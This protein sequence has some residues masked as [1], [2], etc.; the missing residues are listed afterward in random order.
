MGDQEVPA[1][2][3]DPPPA[4]VAGESWVAEVARVRGG[5]PAAFEIIF[6]TFAIP[7]AA[8]A[9]RHVRSR[10]T[11]GELV[12]DVFYRLWRGRASWHVEGSLQAYLYRA[13]RN[14][15]ADFLKHERVA[16]RWAQQSLRE[17]QSRQEGGASSTLDE[18]ESAERT[19]ALE[20]V[21]DELPERRRQVFLL[22]WKEGK[23]YQEIARLL[24]V[25]IKTVENQ[26]NHALRTLRSRLGSIERG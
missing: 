26:M 19:T 1:P 9:Y 5:D 3:D 12:Q 14:R 20:R 4:E 10:D 25:S 16:Q 8:F 24:G 13:V 15:I 17:H 18:L 22:R 23:S 21:L 11:A 2:S 6:R 7:L